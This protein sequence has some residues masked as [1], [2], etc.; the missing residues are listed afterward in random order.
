[1]PQRLVYW[2]GD[3]IPESEARVSIFDFGVMYGDMMFEMTR[4]FNHK[5][6]RLRHHLE[7]LYNSL[8]YGQID[9]G[10]TI[11][12]MEAATLAT[13]EKNIPALDGADCQIMHDVTRGAIPS[14]DGI[15]K[16]GLSPVV[17]INVWPLIRHTGGMA[18]K[19]HEGAHFVYTQQRSVPARYID[20]KAKSRTRLFYR[21]AELEAARLD[22]AASALLTDEHGFI[23]EG[24]GNNF[25]MVRDGEILTPKPHDILRG[26]S[27]GACMDFAQQLGISVNEAD[28]DPYDVREADEAWFTSTTICMIPITKVHFHPVGDGVPGPIYKKLIDAWSNEVG[29]DIPAQAS[30]YAERAKTWKP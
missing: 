29:L 19:Y 26:V 30:D 11:D 5:P 7:R 18:S 20:P 6:F 10:L 14:Y 22:P 23:T 24:T 8:A 12:Q 2:N 27:R 28:I 21:L 13:L 17:S 25:F 15:V 9:C 3:F 16:E 1:M 4:T